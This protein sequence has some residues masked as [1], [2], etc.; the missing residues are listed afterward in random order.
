MVT[1]IDQ[2]ENILSTDGFVNGCFAFT[3]TEAVACSI[4]NEIIRNIS[5]KGGIAASSF[6]KLGIISSESLK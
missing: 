4:R 5:L 1:Y 3:G 6:D 2:N